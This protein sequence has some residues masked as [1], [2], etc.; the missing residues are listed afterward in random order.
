[1]TLGLEE[2]TSFLTNKL[3]NKEPFVFV[4][5]GDGDLYWMAQNPVAIAGGETYRPGIDEELRKA[6]DTL[7]R[8]P[9]VYFGD[10]LTCASGP[11]LESEQTVFIKQSLEKNGIPFQ[12]EEFAGEHV[13]MQTI[14][15]DERWLH[16]ECLLLHR[17]SAEL[18]E[19]YRAV[20]LDGRLKA[21]IGNWKLTASGIMLNANSSLHSVVHE[22][23]AHA[24]KHRIASL[25]RFYTEA[26]WDILLLSAG[27][28]SK[29]IA[30]ALAPQFPNRTII[31]LG[32]ALDPLFIGRTRGEQL[33]PEVAREFFK[34]LL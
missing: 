1:M 23:N 27:R 32:S 16:F 6:A 3:K 21:F 13:S 4:K 28:A 26:Y 15:P 34:D 17:K 25:V 18:L 33:D 2:S 12:L 9:Y 29:L 14:V 30:A 22:N 19:F 24:E 31:E 11:Y 8:L 7:R 5:F 20:K 10:Q